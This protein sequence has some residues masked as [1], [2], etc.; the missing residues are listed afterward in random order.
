MNDR[1]ES[2]LARTRTI[3]WQDPHATAEAGRSLSGMEYLRKIISGEMPPPPMA[4]LMNFQLSE[5]DEGRAVFIIEPAEYHYNPNGVVHGGLAATLLDSAMGC[6][7]H[8][9]L[10]SGV[11]YTTLEVKVNYLRPMTRSTGQLRAEAKTLHVGRT[12]AMAEAK[13]TDA[14]GKLYAAASTTCIIFRS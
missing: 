7:V 12:T 14:K 4:A 13:L 10:P 9:T 2:P 8:S 3:S 6:A 5:L 11:G 1:S